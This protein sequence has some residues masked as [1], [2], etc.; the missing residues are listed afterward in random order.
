MTDHY[1]AQ[2]TRDPRD[3][4]AELFV[5]L[6]DVLRKAIAAPAYAER[7]KGIDPAAVTSRAALAKLPVLRKS[8]LPALHKANPPFGGFVADPPPARSRGSS[9]R[10]APSSSR[11][12]LTPTPG[13]AH[14]RSLPW[15]SG[16]ATSC[17]TPSA[18]I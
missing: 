10:R 15:A 18:I 11:K 14:A 17:S 2:E 6:P 7:L 5:R 1:D 16:R 8:E 12:A 3:R 9:P 13:A 4:E